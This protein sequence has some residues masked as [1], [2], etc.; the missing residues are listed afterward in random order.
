MKRS[1]EFLKRRLEV[2]K[3]RPISAA[4][5]PGFLYPFF[6]TDYMVKVGT[7][8]NPCQRKRQ[9]NTDCYNPLRVWYDPIPCPNSHRAEAIA[10]ILLEMRC[11]DRPK[12]ACLTCGKRH[13]EKFTFN[14][15]RQ[16]ILR[17]VRRV[18]LRA[19]SM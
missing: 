10:H 6:E 9:W 4:D 16:E 5:G 17:R 7:T 8:V 2:L 1:R 14:G 18:L 3:A 13:R 12:R 19:I 11:L 15:T